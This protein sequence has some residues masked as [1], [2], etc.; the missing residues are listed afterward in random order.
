MKRGASGSSRTTSATGASSRPASRAG[1][2]CGLRAARRVGCGRG[3]QRPPRASSSHAVVADQ[4][5]AAVDQRQ[6]Q[7]RLAAARRPSISSARPPIA[8]QVAWWRASAAHAAGQ[9]ERRGTRPAAPSARS[10]TRQRAVVRLDDGAGDGEAE[11]AVVAEV[12]GLG[13]QRVEPREHL[14]AR[15][16]AGCRGRGRRPTSSTALAVAARRRPRSAAGRRE[17]DGVVEQV[18]DHP[19]EPSGIARARGAAAALRATI[20]TRA[21]PFAPRLVARGDQ[22]SRPA[23]PMSTGSNV[24]RLS[25]ASIRLAS[26]ISV[27]RRSIRRTSCAAMSVSWRAQRRVLDPARAIRARCA[28]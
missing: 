3:Q 2:G 8:T 6:R 20:D 14:L 21:P 12:L 25:S 27:T 28:G 5:R 26:A 17:R 1:R 18:V 23:R 24:A 4:H 7:A 16:R 10:A 13:P 11:A 19:F 9:V 15:P 22:R